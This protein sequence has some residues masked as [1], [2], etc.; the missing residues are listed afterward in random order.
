[1]RCPKCGV[2][3]AMMR[4]RTVAVGDQSPDTQTEIWTVMVYQCRNPGCPQ[5]RKDVG[6]T[7][8]RVYPEENPSSTP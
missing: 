7:R 5:H 1:M 8:H 2:E 6:E 3:A 4:T